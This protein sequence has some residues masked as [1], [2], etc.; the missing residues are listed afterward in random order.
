M[1]V[2][3]G[4]DDRIFNDPGKITSNDSSFERHS[5][6]VA[7]VGK[8]YGVSMFE[9]HDQRHPDLLD[10]VDSEESA[11]NYVKQ[12]FNEYGMEDVIFYRPEIH[13]TPQELGEKKGEDDL[14]KYCREGFGR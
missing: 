8:A 9:D 6:F 5:Q 14:F 3:C 12:M 10:S 13:S 4:L 2:Q 11:L 1:R 7:E